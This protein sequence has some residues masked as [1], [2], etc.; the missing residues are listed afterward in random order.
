MYVALRQ[1]HK[2]LQHEV[3]LS[4]LGKLSTVIN[5]SLFMHILWEF[6][7]VLRSSS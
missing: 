6:I 1:L 2:S 4:Y 7:A 5:D 3:T